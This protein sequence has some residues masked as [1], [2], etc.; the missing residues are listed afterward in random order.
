MACRRSMSDVSLAK[1][2]IR[3]SAGREA[4]PVA[5]P[6]EAGRADKGGVEAFSGGGVEASSGGV[7]VDSSS[8]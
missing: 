6:G 5:A 7:F 2:R 3:I 8:L 1:T 4:K